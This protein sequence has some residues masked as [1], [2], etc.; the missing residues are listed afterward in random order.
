MSEAQFQCALLRSQKDL[1]RLHCLHDFTIALCNS[2]QVLVYIQHLRS[3]LAVSQAW[4][5]R[6]SS[7]QGRTRLD[8]V[9]N[10][11]SINSIQ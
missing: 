6:P 10:N 5:T 7:P 3:T 1:M 2:F 11:E 4:Q 8:D 9:A